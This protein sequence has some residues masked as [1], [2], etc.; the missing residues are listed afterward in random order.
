MLLDTYLRDFDV[1]KL[2]IKLGHRNHSFNHDNFENMI[3]LRKYCK[4]K[5]QQVLTKRSFKRKISPFNGNV[6]IHNPYH[7]ESI[8]QNLRHKSVKRYR[9]EKLQLAD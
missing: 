1:K 5:V 2:S 9:N 3:N 4:S 6:S 7:R 8:E